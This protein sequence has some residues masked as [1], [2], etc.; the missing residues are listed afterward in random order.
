[1]DFLQSVVNY[2]VKQKNLV[3]MQSVT[4]SVPERAIR[5]AEALVREA[6]VRRFNA[7]QT[8]LNLGMPIDIAEVEKLTDDQL[9]ERMHFLGLPKSIN[10]LLDSKKTTGNLIPLVA[11]F[12]GVVIG[13]ELVIGEVVEPTH[14]QFTLADVSRVWITLNVDREDASR[15][16]IGQEIRF[17]ADGVSRE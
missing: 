12:D 14:T 1:A 15:L 10:G 11:P 3:R 2:D 16:D 6:R 5:E 17:L 7:Q 13:R 8:L 9:T 4:D